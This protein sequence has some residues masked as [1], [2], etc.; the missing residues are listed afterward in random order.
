MMTASTVWTLALTLPFSPITS[1]PP[2]VISPPTS[3]ST[4]IESAMS[5]L[6][7]MRARSPTTV[8]SGTEP[9]LPFVSSVFELLNIGHSLRH[10]T[11]RVSVWV[12]LALS[13]VAPPIGGSQPLWRHTP[14][15]ALTSGSLAPQYRK[16]GARTSG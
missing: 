1:L 15:G 5:N 7:S 8:S 3:H 6:P 12:H 16:R 10:E 11:A 4:W 2:T 13:G 9:G 14:G